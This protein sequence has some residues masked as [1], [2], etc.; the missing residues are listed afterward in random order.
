MPPTAQD[1]QDALDS[2][3]HEAERSGKRYVD[4]KSG[5]LHRLVGGYP[6]RNHRM[7]VCCEVMRRNMRPDDQIL[8]QPPSGQGATL[9]IRYKL[10]RSKVEQKTTLPAVRTRLQ[11]PKIGEEKLLDRIEVNPRVMVGKP[12][13]RGTRLTV[14]FILSFLAGGAT[15]EEILEEYE[16]LT[17]EDILAC[18]LFASRCLSETDFMPLEK[19]TT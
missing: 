1:F 17:R 18:L 16:G 4:V 7:P 12:V 3:F 11:S 14:E 5:D 6:G 19:G 15:I 9:V 10:P 2:I 13:I 8:H